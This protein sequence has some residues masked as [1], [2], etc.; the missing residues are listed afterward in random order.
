MSGRSEEGMFGCMCVCVVTDKVGL[1]GQERV[2]L[3]LCV[4]SDLS[5]LKSMCV[6]VR[7]CLHRVM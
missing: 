2:C 5:E 7:V 6:C 3:G 1:G 4:W